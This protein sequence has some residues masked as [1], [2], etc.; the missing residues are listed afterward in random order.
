M[1]CAQIGSYQGRTPIELGYG[2]TPEDLKNINKIEPFPYKLRSHN[3]MSSQS[4]SAP[5]MRIGEDEDDCSLPATPNSVRPMTADRPLTADP[6]GAISSKLKLKHL[7]AQKK[8]DAQQPPPLVPSIR[9]SSRSN[10][11]RLTARSC[12]T[13]LSLLTDRMSRREQKQLSTRRSKKSLQKFD[14]RKELFDLT[15][16]TLRSNS[17]RSYRSCR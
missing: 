14:S 13:S 1:L 15:Q 2:A 5:G 4:K 10:A 8:R 7:S 12:A 17:Q 6:T 3:M 11:P 16:S 9:L